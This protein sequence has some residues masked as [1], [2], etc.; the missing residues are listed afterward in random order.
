MTELNN[1][2]FIEIEKNKDGENLDVIKQLLS[3]G[4]NVNGL[5]VT[6]SLIYT[7]LSIAC[8][9]GNTAL[10]SYLIEMGADKEQ[11]L[12]GV[13]PM[14]QACNS[15]NI[16]TVLMLIDKGVKLDNKSSELFYQKNCADMAALLNSAPQPQPS[17]YLTLALQEPDLLCAGVGLVVALA[18][19]TC[20]VS[21]A[22]TD[23]IVAGAVLFTAGCAFFATTTSSV[24]NVENTAQNKETVEDMEERLRV[25]GYISSK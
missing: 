13:T 22:V 3:N 21:L 11:C 20:G 8:M 10:A 7:P 17:S 24:K 4:A 18:L 23:V 14:V 6:D 2:L 19:L 9:N 1:Q 15:G 25:A 5:S 12:M 16:K